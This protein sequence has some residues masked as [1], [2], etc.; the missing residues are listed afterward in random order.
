MVLSVATI[1]LCLV[2][3]F[4]DVFAF[5]SNENLNYELNAEIDRA[6]RNGN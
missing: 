4:N 1:T 6:R 3:V 2:S 5:P